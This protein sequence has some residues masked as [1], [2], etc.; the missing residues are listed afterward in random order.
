MG[1]PNAVGIRE[2]HGNTTAGGSAIREK[3]GILVKNIQL[4]LR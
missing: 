4:A 2:K 3:L 1:I